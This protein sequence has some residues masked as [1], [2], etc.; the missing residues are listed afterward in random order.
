MNPMI[1]K[2]LRQR[3]RERRGWLLPSLY[4]VV[5][6]AV[7]TFAYFV[8]TESRGQSG[9]QGSTVGVVL[10]LT[11]AYSQLALLLLLVPYIDR[12]T[13]GVGKW[14]ARERLLANTIFLTLV[15]VNVM[16]IIIGTFFRGPNWSMVL[17]W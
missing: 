3:M 10:F 7:V 5:L 16:F 9:I 1:R 17:P 4:L 14:F 6:G 8:T 13:A 12:G 15:L 2:E 11:L